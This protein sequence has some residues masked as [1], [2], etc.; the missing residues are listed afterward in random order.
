MSSGLSDFL[1]CNE[2]SQRG[3]DIGQL[4]WKVMFITEGRISTCDSARKCKI[5]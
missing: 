1:L 3:Q 4:V 5:T 2:V